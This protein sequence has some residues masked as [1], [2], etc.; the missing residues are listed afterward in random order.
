MLGNLRAQTSSSNAYERT[1]KYEDG[2]RPRF[3]TEFKEVENEVVVATEV[4]AADAAGNT[5]SINV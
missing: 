2:T 5:A 4:M 3:L 1:W